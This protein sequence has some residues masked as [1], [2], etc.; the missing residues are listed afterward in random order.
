MLRQKYN[1]DDSLNAGVG[2]PRVEFTGRGENSTKMSGA[3]FCKER[4]GQTD[5]NRGAEIPKLDSVRFESEM[6][7]E[8]H[9]VV[10][11]GECMRD[12]PRDTSC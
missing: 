10:K 11:L 12:I 7:D 3:G 5:T 6:R 9:G 1:V 4:M 8:F 2:R